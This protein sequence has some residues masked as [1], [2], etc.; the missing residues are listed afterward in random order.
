[1]NMFKQ[2]EIKDYA[3]EFINDQ[4][5]NIDEIDQQELH[6]D[7]FNTEYYI[8]GYYESIKWLESKVFEIIVVIKDYEQK[9]FGEVTTDFSSSE[10]VVN[11][12]VYIVGEIVLSEIFDE[13]KE[14]SND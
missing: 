3:L 10:A 7:I 9:N 11:M 13:Q 6:H 5:I 2:E 12:Y 1:M 14:E 8:I 4:N